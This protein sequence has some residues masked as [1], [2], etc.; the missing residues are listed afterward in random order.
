MRF[1][2]VALVALGAVAAPVAAQRVEA[3][4]TV[5]GR[6][7]WWNAK[8]LDLSASAPSPWRGG[9]FLGPRSG[10]G[11]SLARAGALDPG[12]RAGPGVGVLDTLPASPRLLLSGAEAPPVDGGA[13]LGYRYSNWTFSSA[14][15]QS[16]DDPRLAAT[17]IDLGATY[18]IP[19]TERHLITLSGGLTLGQSGASVPAYYLAGAD[20]LSRR[21]LRYGEPGAGFRVSWLYTL[22]RNL[23]V[24]TSLGYDRLYGDPGEGLGSDRATTTFGT[25]FGYRY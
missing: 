18:G 12:L 22:D 5:P 9:A 10:Q 7:Q 20:A 19:V 3:P 17:R 24:S 15:R 1:V 11:F 25:V 8:D 23:Y 13:Y 21:T 14:V 6:A 16:L 4:G 2:L